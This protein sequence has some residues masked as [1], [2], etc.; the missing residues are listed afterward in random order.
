[1]SFATFILENIEPILKEWEAF[2]QTLLPTSK[3]LSSAGL[4]DHAEQILVAIA[5]DIATEQS[6][7]DQQNKSFGWQPRPANDSDTAAEVHADARYQSGFTLNEVVTEYR[8]LRA[9]VIRL[10]TQQLGEANRVNL[11]ELTRFNEALDQGQS[12]AIVRYSA[13]A[14]RTRDLILGALGHDLRNPLSAVSYSAQYLMRAEKLDHGLIRTVTRI[15]T[16][17]AR[18]QA[19]IR[20]LLDFARTRLGEQLPIARAPM[21]IGEACRAAIDEIG[22]FHPDR[23]L[24]FDATGDLSGRWDSG[25]I[26][27]MLSNLVSNA[28]QHGAPDG[29]VSVSG[30]GSDQAV[31][32]SIHNEGRPIPEH[33]WRQIF[34]PLAHD[35]SEPRNRRSDNRNLGLGLYIASEIATAHGGKLELMSSI[36]AGTTFAAVLPRG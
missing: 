33:L 6:A 31:R 18:M 14:E 19:M 32:V 16:S 25:R 23:T 8:A 15:V 22:A 5:K 7:A 3:G 28:V 11:D 13:R 20:D 27:Q 10:W 17:T 12:E 36:E 21:D 35:A 26:G 1:V 9:S 34:E 29:P 2:A 4:R 30:V 24:T